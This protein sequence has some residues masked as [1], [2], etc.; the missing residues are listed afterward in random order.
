MLFILEMEVVLKRQKKSGSDA[1][2][3]KGIA[4]IFLEVADTYETVNHLLTFGLDIRW[5]KKAAAEASQAGGRAWLDVCSGTGEMARYLSNNAETNVTV[6]ALDFTP[7]MLYHASRKKTSNRV[8]FVLGDAGQ[9]PF[10][11][12]TFDLVTISF[13]TR[14]INLSRNILIR[15]LM[16]FN[17]VLKRGGWFMNLETSQPQWRFFRALFHLYV[18]IM[19]PPIGFLV[20]G[21]KAGYRYLASTIPRFYPADEFTRII[22]EAGF[23]RVVCRHMLFG[24][25]AV[26]IAIKDSAL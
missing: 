19:V 22:R 8:R 14:N 26:H 15:H 7:S 10:P 25:A 20:S 23:G 6:V 24:I 4:K 2:M 11:E 16:E 17:R 13:A 9:L 12:E 21:S 3:K 1:G 5:R 18:K